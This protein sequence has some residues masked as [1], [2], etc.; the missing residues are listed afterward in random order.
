MWLTREV[1]KS[2]LLFDG[3]PVLV[4][5]IIAVR[6]RPAGLGHGCE[7]C[8]CRQMGRLISGDS[9]MAGHPRDGDVDVLLMKDALEFLD[10]L[11]S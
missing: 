8:T 5:V 1:R 3:G 11:N 4:R 6:R 9:G 10:L 2:P 7:Q